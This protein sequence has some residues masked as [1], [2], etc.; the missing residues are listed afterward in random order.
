V[1]PRHQIVRELDAVFLDDIH[2][3]AHQIMESLQ[4][5]NHFPAK[6]QCVQSR[7]SDNSV[8]PGGGATTTK[9]SKDWRFTL[10]HP[11][12]SEVNIWP[13][14]TQFEAKLTV[15]IGGP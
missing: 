13:M 11:S 9:N 4:E 10:S 5:S 6:P 14:T 3:T 7:T 2:V 8:K 15:A 12:S 1:D